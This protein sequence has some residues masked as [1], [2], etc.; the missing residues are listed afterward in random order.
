[1]MKRTET[2]ALIEATLAII[3]WG[4]SFIFMK[5]VLREISAVT[6]IV[7]RYALG[8]LCV[9]PFAWWRGDFSRFSAADVPGLAGAGALGI[10]LQ[11]LL[12]VSGQVSADASVAAFLA[13]TAPAFTVL[14]AAGWLHERLHPRQII[15]VI[16]ASLGGIAV[17]IGGDWLALI[18]GHAEKT[19]FGNVLILLSAIVWAIFIILSKRMVQHRPAALVTSGMFFFGLFFT[20]PVFFA[21]Q[22]WLEIPRLSPGGWGATLYV[23]ILSTAV[24]YLLNSHALKVISA[25]RVAV[26]QNLEPL[27]A[28]AGAALVLNESMSW[29]MLLGGAAIL[30]GVYLAERHV[31]EIAELQPGP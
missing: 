2:L 13:A 19:L 16:L 21:Q 12:Q 17:A 28:V 4:I 20:L 30:S 5:I 6:L 11:Q 31:P 10:T 26:I 25:A 24:A 1:M 29:A 27:V 9:L 15:G 14:L 7:L 22:G 23:G 18:Q 8:A 3:I